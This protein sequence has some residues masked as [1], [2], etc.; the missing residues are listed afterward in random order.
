M[1]LVVVLVL[2]C[3]SCAIVENRTSTQSAKAGD[4]KIAT[5]GQAMIGRIDRGGGPV[6]EC[7]LIYMGTSGG[8]AIVEYREFSNGMARPAFTERYELPLGVVSCKEWRFEIH[9]ATGERVRFTV[10]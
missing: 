3:T 7:L 2:A 9:E 4:V 10:H 5:V 1:R 8:S 6:F